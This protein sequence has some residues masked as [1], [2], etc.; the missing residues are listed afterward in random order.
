M[1][2]RGGVFFSINQN[3]KRDL[4]DEARLLAQMGYIIYA[5]HGTADYLRQN[6][7]DVINLH[8]MREKRSPNPIEEIQNGNLQLIINI[9]DSQNTR[10]DA[11]AIRQEAIRRRVF[12]VTTVAG[13]KSLVQGLKEMHDQNFSVRS[14]QAIHN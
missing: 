5:T 9:P 2:A 6:G 8:K 1:P 14:L 11:F 3:V 10:D 4:L 13:A 7:V 12:C